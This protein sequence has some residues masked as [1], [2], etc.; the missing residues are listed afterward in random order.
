MVLDRDIDMDEEFNTEKRALEVA[1][2]RSGVHES[3]QKAMAKVGSEFEYWS[4]KLTDTSLQMCY[5]LI[6]ANWVVFGS[7][8]QILR[9]NYAKL[10]LLMVILTL[11]SNVIGSWYLSESLRRRFEWAESHEAEWKKE[12]DEAVGKRDPFP[13]L[14]RHERAGLLVRQIKGLFPL[15]GGMFLLIGA[16]LK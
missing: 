2:K 11:A 3:P 10:S 6:G 12:F 8:G 13:F 9:D 16:I 7:V 1:A 4:G 5:A 14:E 15:I